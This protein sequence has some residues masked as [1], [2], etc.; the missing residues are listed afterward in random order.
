M[1]DFMFTVWDVEHGLAI[2]IRTPNNHNHCI[3]LGHNNDENFSPFR[4][5]KNR[6]W[7]SRIN[8]LIISH[9]DKDHLE[10]LP[11]F[12]TLFGYPDTFM[13]NKTLPE[14]MMYGDCEYDYQIEFQ[15]MNGTFTA[16]VEFATSTLNPQVN[17]GVDVRIFLNAFESGMSCNDTSVV[18]FYSYKDYL[19]VCPGDIEPAGWRNLMSNPAT[20][21]DIN[22]L[23][24][25][26]AIRLLVAPHHGRNSG[27]CQDMIG[28]L[29]PHLVLISDKYGKEPT[30]PGFYE[31]GLGL[32]VGGQ[33]AKLLSTKT[34]GRI[35]FMVNSEGNYWVDTAN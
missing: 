6:Y 29:E 2:W 12:V 16:P 32:N 18:A 5:M 17:G 27:Y 33:T 8:Y 14:Y 10:G 23:V 7:V 20:A 26:A 1:V 15:H 3:D 22:K 28:V 34:N 21:N 19:F 9:P 35:Q 25:K 30:A 13:R 11:N 31:A 4:H 24:N